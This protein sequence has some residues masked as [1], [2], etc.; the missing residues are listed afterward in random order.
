[1]LMLRCCGRLLIFCILLWYIRIFLGFGVQFYK[2][3][4]LMQLILYVFSVIWL[5]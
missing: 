4:I 2:E 5:S 3:R 1:M